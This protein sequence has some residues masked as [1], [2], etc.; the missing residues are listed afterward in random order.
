MSPLLQALDASSAP[1]H[2][3]PVE[4]ALL[5]L[6]L[7]LVLGQAIAWT[8]A[9]THTGLSYSRTFTQSLVLLTMIVSLV[10]MV[11]GNNIITAF[12]L[13]GALAII[14]FRNV[15]K[16]TR[17]TVFVFLAL[18]VG[19]AAGSEKYVTA[20][21]GTAATALVI[22]YL[23]YTSFGTLGRFDGHLSLLAAPME[24]GDAF[25][26]VLRRF[27]RS[28]KRMSVRQSGSDS[29]AE[30]I[31][32]IRLRDRERSQELLDTLRTTPGVADVSLVLRDELHEL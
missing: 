5:G 22:L 4:S 6:L 25:T 16:D 8:Y 2:E 12:G 15:L 1:L 27:C 19:M 20:I 7:A 21:I 29:T 32:Q 28:V 30:Y 18:V 26:S 14:R 3:G 23:H 13:I 11:I 9:A 17:D 31:F 10:M 24:D